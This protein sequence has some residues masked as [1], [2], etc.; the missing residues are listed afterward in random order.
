[1]SRLHLVVLFSCV[2]GLASGCSQRSV[3]RAD[4]EFVGPVESGAPLGPP[5]PEQVFGPEDIDSRR[6]VLFLGPGA[7][8]AL[9]AAGVIRALEEVKIEVA[10]IVAME[11]GAL[12]GAAYATTGSANEMD[13][14]LLQFKPEWISPGRGLGA[15]LGARRSS[16]EALREGMVKLFSSAELATTK[17]P[18]W[19]IV[20]RGRGP[21]AIHQGSMVSALVGTLSQK[22][23]I[24]VGPEGQSP[25]AWGDLSGLLA[26]EGLNIPG[27]WVVPRVSPAWPAKAAVSASEEVRNWLRPNDLLLELDPGRP[28]DFVQRSTWVYAG[29]KKCR[30]AL[31]QWQASLGWG[32]A[33]R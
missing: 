28:W 9:G 6:V 24:E 22:E 5:A 13:W 11:L 1:M 25:H 29:K 27:V 16:P 12:V 3:R 21:E 20:D 15:L 10:G 23:I 33:I 7:P 26:R 18:L 19:I 8:A 2:L 31:P 17:K 30:A 4:P 32:E 14:K